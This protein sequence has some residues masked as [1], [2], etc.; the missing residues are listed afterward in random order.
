MSQGN[1]TDNILLKNRRTFTARQSMDS[2]IAFARYR[3][4]WA[5]DQDEKIYNRSKR[6]HTGRLF[7][8]LSIVAIPSL[9]LVYVIV[10]SSRAWPSATGE[11]S[12]T[13]TC[14]ARPSK[15]AK[16]A[17][18]AS[19]SCRRCTWRSGKSG[20]SSWD[21]RTPRKSNLFSGRNQQPDLQLY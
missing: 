12:T 2:L 5:R 9:Y 13:A 17:T 20:R 21:S 6:L 1:N 19:S 3:L 4:D 7:A 10:A 18:T 16:P 11:T 14:W 15:P 8:V